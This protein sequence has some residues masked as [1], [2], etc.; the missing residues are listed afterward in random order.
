[1][2]LREHIVGKTID[3][4]ELSEPQGGKYSIFNVDPALAEHFASAQ[5]ERADANYIFASSGW[6]CE[7]G[8]SDGK[9]GFY[10]NSSDAGASRADRPPTGGVTVN[11]NFTDGSLLRYELA[12]WSNRL[13][14]RQIDS[15]IAF[16]FR[17]KFPL[18]VTDPDDFTYSN[19]LAWMA[20]HG[21]ASVLEAMALA[22]G[23]TD[24][25]TSLMLFILWVSQV[26]PKRKVAELQPAELRTVFENTAKLVGEY[27]RGERLAPHTDIFGVHSGDADESLALF[28]SRGLGAPCPKCMT[29]LQAVSGG[30]TKL[31]FC[32]VCQK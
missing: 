21:K 15:A 14:L 18:D 19:Y 28:T 9:I 25:T 24:I 17:S 3:R 8:Y 13:S 30:G 4:L 12:G 1:M 6:L 5:V 27:Q 7:I 22:K 32:P 2:Q 11:F 20:T 10:R 23:A 16:P 29:P 26:K 31:Y